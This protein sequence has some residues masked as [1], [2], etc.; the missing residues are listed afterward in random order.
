VIAASSVTAAHMDGP[1]NCKPIWMD[2]ALCCRLLGYS[3]VL[4][5]NCCIRSTFPRRGDS[6]SLGGSIEHAG[7]LVPGVGVSWM[8]DLSVSA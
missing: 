1:V 4:R 3:C 6:D 7:C 5:I 8:M 2:A